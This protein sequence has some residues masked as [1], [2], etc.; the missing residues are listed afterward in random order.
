MRF[1]PAALFILALFVCS[2]CPLP[3]F[4]GE[5]EREILV[6]I[7]DLPVIFDVRPVL[8][9]GRTLVPFRAVAEALD[10]RVYWDGAARTVEA[11]DGETRVVLQLGSRKA[12]IDG[13]A[14]SLDVPPLILDGRTLIPLRFFSEAFN[15]HV[16][17]DPITSRVEITSGPRKMTVVGFYALGDSRTSSWTNLFRRAYPETD[18]GN[19]DVVDELALGWYSFDEQGALLTRSWTGWQRP[20]GWENVLLAAQKYNLKTEMTIYIMDRYGTLSSLL[21]D[22][23]ASARLIGEIVEEAALYGGV[24][25]NFE[26]YGLA[27]AG[28]DLHVSR[29][30]LTDFVRA[31]AAQLKAA[32][33]SLTLTI[34]P[35]NSAY[36]G[37]DYG[38]LGEIADRIII[39]AYDYGL[40]PEPVSLVLQAVEM[41]AEVVPPQK[42]LLGICVP[43]E[44]AESIKAKLGIAKRYGLN[45]IALWRLGLVTPEMWQALRSHVR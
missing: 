16:S 11:T 26:E 4:A 30:R 40:R 42:L 38:A 43:Y 45:G 22:Q 9:D 33:K 7:D 32:H 17:W 34:H 36:R 28:E 21:A 18:T 19:T 29:Q 37:Y 44:T 31:L 5:Q 27:R 3:A 15:C 1:F 23:G 35:P 2:I 39:M 41:A 24:N 14:F 20:S 6:L 13:R 10:V 8:R 12:F 25:L